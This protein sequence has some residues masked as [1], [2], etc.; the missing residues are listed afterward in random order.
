M[1]FE[2]PGGECSDWFSEL[3][4]NFCPATGAAEARTRSPKPWAFGANFFILTPQNRGPGAALGEE[5]FG[6]E[7]DDRDLSSA[8]EGSTRVDCTYSF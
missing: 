1:A 7:R 2:M 8:A 5:G 4:I 3:L 6:E